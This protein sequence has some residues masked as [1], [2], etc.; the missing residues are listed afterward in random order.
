MDRGLAIVITLAA[1]GLVAFQPPVNA[2][3]S[4]Q[5]GDLGAAFTSLAIS[6][7][8]IAIALVASGELGTLRGLG[9]F[10][11]HHV[12]GGVAGAAIVYVSLVTVRS[13]GAAGVAAALVA[14]QLIV[15]AVLDR[16]GVLGL[17]ETGFSAARIAG[18]VLLVAGTVLVVSR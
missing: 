14:A 1:G 12:L 2:A 15:A 16:L 7:V 8:I 5:T 4:R 9:E 6:W 3:L 18:I 11:P 10:R 13:L 17:E